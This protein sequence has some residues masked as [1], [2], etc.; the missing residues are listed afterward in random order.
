MLICRKGSA[1][2]DNERVES[3]VVGL[4]QTD[5][6]KR[7]DGSFAELREGEYVH[8]FMDIVDEDKSYSYVVSEGT[9]IRN[10]YA[11]KPYKWCCQL[12][13]VIEYIEDYLKKFPTPAND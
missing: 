11:F 8:L 6:V 5:L 2:L 12:N 13:G 3:N 1:D 10:P 9:V 4:T 7:F